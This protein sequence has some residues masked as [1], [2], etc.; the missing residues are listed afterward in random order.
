ML[1]QRASAGSGKTFKLAKTYI[2]LFIAAREEG[3]EFYRLLTP[4]EVRERH[5]HILGVTFTNKATNEMKQ[6]IV[7]KLAALS[8]PVPAEG[9]EPE[10]Y[11]FPDYMLEFTGEKQG[12]DPVEDILYVSRGI[13]A[14]RREVT[15]TCRAA[16][17]SLLNDYGNFNIS[18]IDSFFQG[19]LRTLAYELHLNDAYHVELND[20]YLAQVG[21][22]EALGS[23]KDSH[24][25]DGASRYMSDWLRALMERRLRHGESWDAFS[26]RGGS[27]IYGELLAMAGKMSREDFKRNMAGM[28]E[29]F[30]EPDRFMRFWQGCLRASEK[31][32]ELHREAVEAARRFRQETS[33]ESWNSGVATGLESILGSGPYA[34]P[35]T[36]VKF[37]RGA[38]DWP[39]PLS[40]RDKPFKKGSFEAEDGY[41]QDLFRNVCDTLHEWQRERA[42]RTTVLSRLH[43]MGALH[44]I[45]ANIDAFREEN[46]V[47][48]LSATNDILHRIID[49]DEVPFIYERTGVRLRHF[50]LDEFQDTSA[51]QWS[52]LRPLLEQSEACGHENLIIGDAKQSIYRFRNADPELI[53]RRVEEDFPQTRVAPDPALAGTPA[54]EAVNTNWRSSRHVVSFNNS[55]FSELARVLDNDRPGVFTE[56]YANVV[57]RV[58]HGEQGGYVHVDFESKEGFS[59]LGPLIDSLRGRGWRLSDIAVLTDT[60]G[61]GQKAIGHIISHNREMSASDPSYTPIEFISEESLLVGESAAVKVILAVMALIARDFIVPKEAAETEEGE[62]K[63]GRLRRRELERLVANYNIGVW[64]GDI[65]C[66]ADVAEA[67]TVVSHEEIEALYRRMGAVTLPALVEG[68][69]SAFLTEGMQQTQAAYICAF[70]DAVLQYCDTY[71]ADPGS[72]LGWWEENG[73]RLS[74]AAPE[75]TEAVQVMTVHKSKGLEFGV[76]IVPCADWPVGPAKEEREVMWVEH[77]PEGLTAD[78]EADAP[79]KIPV[80]PN[81]KTMTDPASPFHEAYM[82][83]REECRTDQLNKTYVAFTRAVRELYVTAPVSHAERKGGEPTRIGGWMLRALERVAAGDRR[84]AYL[85]DAAECEM[86]GKSFSY[87]DPAGPGHGANNRGQAEIMYIER[88][89]PVRG[90]GCG[91]AAIALGTD[92]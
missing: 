19:V 72:F 22:D 37:E 3:T 41:A 8:R 25:A 79:A 7:D 51:M 70:Q 89:S 87:G 64:R 53:T 18:T 11:R 86:D 34:V 38:S 21:V 80:T 31:V 39:L 58:S 20:E 77:V 73:G 40:G 10:G 36:G 54:Y 5:G 4:V 66:V 67:E 27:G 15:E 45:N 52:N 91:Q 59:G 85:V 16:L 56:L 2:R 69:A 28:E 68:I 57:Q 55:L 84:G 83:F 63:S 46:N 26:K 92:E 90:L 50:L 13:R 43:Y 9:M 71:P 44:F 33:P 32:T 74:I 29:Y 65:G 23:V 6:R 78:E 17:R 82:R 49:G 1:L 12:A 62:R 35:T 61:D 75:G 42:Y 14:T 81:G 76:V 48:P 24:E 30:D 47:I 60:R 88:Y